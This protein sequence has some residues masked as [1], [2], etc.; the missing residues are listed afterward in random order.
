MLTTPRARVNGPV[1]VLG[2][3]AGLAVAGAMDAL[4][5]P[6]PTGRERTVLARYGS[7]H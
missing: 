3:L 2:W 5:S 6:E 1:F 7:P 4:A